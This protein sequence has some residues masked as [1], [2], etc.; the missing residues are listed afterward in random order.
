LHTDLALHARSPRRSCVR[1]TWCM[2]RRALAWR[3][4]F[5]IARNMGR[6]MLAVADLDACFLERMQLTN[7][8]V[9]RTSNSCT[10]REAPLRP[11]LDVRVLHP[12][13]PLLTAKAR[14]GVGRADPKSG[15]SQLAGLALLSDWLGAARRPRSRYLEVDRFCGSTGRVTLERGS[16]RGPKVVR[17]PMRPRHSSGPIDESRSGCAYDLVPSCDVEILLAPR[18]I[19]RARDHGDAAIGSRHL[20]RLSAPV[21]EPRRRLAGLSE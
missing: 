8:R 14:R 7:G 12:L 13:A 6:D 5:E 16:D 3:F 9:R 20:V 21:G 10:E 17:R 4:G 2:R 19:V 15:V 1:P 11:R 18:S